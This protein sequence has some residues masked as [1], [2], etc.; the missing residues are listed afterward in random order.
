LEKQRP[1][2]SSSFTPR[3]HRQPKELI[4]QYRNLTTNINNN[5]SKKE[6][7]VALFGYENTTNWHESAITQLKTVV[8]FIQY[9][10]VSLKL[11]T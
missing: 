3:S 2:E 6:L 10:E 8:I 11:T 1:L 7:Q 9:L 5:T 4:T